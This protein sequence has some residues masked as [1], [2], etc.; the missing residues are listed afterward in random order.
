MLDVKLIAVDLD[1]TFLNG[2]CKV[3]ERNREAVTRAVDK[4]IIF[5]VATGRMRFRIP[6][7]VISIPGLRYVVSANGAS[8]V[9][10]KTGDILYEDPIPAHT[11]LE[12]VRELKKY[13]I[14]ME[15][16][17]RGYAY[18]DQQS[19]SCYSPEIYSRGR[20]TI[21]E[22]GIH[23]VEDIEAFVSD[24]QNTV[25]KINIP[26]IP[27]K[28][29]EEVF[30]IL[31]RPDITATQSLPKN[32]EVNHITANKA[33]GLR[34]VCRMLDIDPSDV[35]AFGDANNDVKMMRFAGHSVAMGNGCPEVKAAA[36]YVTK[37]NEED[38]V[39]W[40]IENNVL[41]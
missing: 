20:R 31:D 38:G 1:D 6:E 13:P 17:H 22:R 7:D 33:E 2:D 41:I 37:T 19:L 15:M 40:F 27:P 9:D 4:G 39:A 16:Y 30:K 29:S 3:S 34:F 14:Y 25:D 11:A 26:F 23:L 32:A 18:T 24:P 21:M 5:T 12:V 36:R 35:M 28:Y 10:L 8:V